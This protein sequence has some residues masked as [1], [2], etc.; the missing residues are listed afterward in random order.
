MVTLSAVRCSVLMGPDKDTDFVVVGI[1]SS[2]ST[3]S[4]VGGDCAVSRE[5]DLRGSVGR[6]ISFRGRN[7]GSSRNV[8]PECEGARLEAQHAYQS[9][10]R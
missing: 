5:R 4:G 1:G 2:P 7:S 10:N 9:K 3:V 6:S 8:S